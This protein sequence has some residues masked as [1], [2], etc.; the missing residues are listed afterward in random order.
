MS[1]VDFS[2]FDDENVESY[3]LWNKKKKDYKL[4]QKD[5]IFE[6]VLHSIGSILD[7]RPAWRFILTEKYLF[8]FKTKKPNKIKGFMRVDGV[9]VSFI[10]SE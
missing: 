7:D 9:R 6:G 2:I 1:E 3:S 8:Y 5:I 4:N 10:K